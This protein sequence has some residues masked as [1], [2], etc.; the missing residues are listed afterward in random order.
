M[1]PGIVLNEFMYFGLGVV[2]VVT[3]YVYVQHEGNV[4]IDTIAV[5]VFG[6]VGCISP[7]E[8]CHTNSKHVHF[9]SSLRL[10]SHLIPARPYPV[11][12]G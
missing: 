11:G 8:S 5:G 6:N 3:T 12:L 4:L 1:F 10:E 2:G 7:E 9:G